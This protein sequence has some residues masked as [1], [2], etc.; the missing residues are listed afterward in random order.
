[1]EGADCFRGNPRGPQ[2]VDQC[3]AERY[4]SKTKLEAPLHL[5]YYRFR[6]RPAVADRLPIGLLHMDIKYGRTAENRAALAAAAEEAA[7]LGAE[8]ILAPELSVSGYSFDSRDEV[9]PYAETLT[10]ETVTLLRQTARRHGIYICAGLAE[11]DPVT[12]IYYNSACVL[13]PAGELTAHHRKIACE[14]RWACPGAPSHTNIFDTPWGRIGVL[15]CADSYYGLLPR[16]LALYGVDL[17]LIPANW[18]PSG[19]DPRKLWRARA[20]ENGVGVIACNRTGV[21]RR[22]DCRQCASY[23]VTADGEVLLDA[24]SESSCVRLVEYS[25]ARGR[26]PTERREAMLAQRRPA[27]FGALYLDVNGLEDFSGLWGLPECGEIDIRCVIPDSSGS[28]LTALESASCAAFA[29]PTLFVLPRGVAPLPFR[30]LETFVEQG[31]IAVITEQEGQNGDAPAYHFIS[32]TEQAFLPTGRSSITVDFGPARI[33]L[34]HLDRLRHPEAVV[35]L[36]KQG[37]DLVVTGAQRLDADDRLLLGVKCLERTAIVASAQDGAV[38][39]EPPPGHAP[40]K[41]TAIYGP[42]ICAARIDTAPLRVKRFLDR[43]DMEA[44]LRR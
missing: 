3:A 16:T 34:A 39:C 13:G 42:G 1:M 44:L 20:L 12:N 31:A 37:C 4:Q 28:T 9:A 24:V 2:N 10:E 43:V 21:D 30:F 33:A 18:P 19:L 15:I 27:E 26:F 38:I 29:A 22:M 32:S 36:S 17:L 41:E 40:W 23:A 8:L 25:L 11:R 5:L 35:A 7:R 6:R 14:R